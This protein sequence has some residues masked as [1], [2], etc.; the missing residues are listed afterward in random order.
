MYNFLLASNTC[1]REERTENVELLSVM[2]VATDEEQLSMIAWKREVCYE[3][4]SL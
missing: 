2:S 3:C 1:E 4:V